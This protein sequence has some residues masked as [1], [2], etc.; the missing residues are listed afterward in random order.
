MKT[1]LIVEDDMMIARALAIRVKSAGYQA[2]LAHDAVSGV[3]LARKNQ[4]D[5]VLLDINMP[6]GDGFLV[7]ERIN[8]QSTTMIPIVFLT[9]SKQPGFREKA[10]LLGLSR[11]LKNHTN[12]K[13]C[14]K[15]SQMRL[16][17]KLGIKLRGRIH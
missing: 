2:L 17:I 12:Q 9:A 14:S 10:R 5:L 7:A 13:S 3:S 4:P 16:G 11:T 6:A 1:I 15:R 8:R